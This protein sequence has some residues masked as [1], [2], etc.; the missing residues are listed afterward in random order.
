MAKLL[1]RRQGFTLVELLVVIAVIGILV[2][3]LLPAIQAA[4]EA[5][6]RT[7]CSNN[8]KQIGLACQNHHDVF[9]TFPSGGLAWSSPRTWLTPG[10]PAGADSQ[11]WGWAYQILPYME[12]RVVWEN[13]NDSEVPGTAI[14]S[15]SCP[16]LRMPTAFPYTQAGFNETRMMAD[17]VGNGGTWGGWGNFDNSGNSLDGPLSP[18]GRQVRL[19]QITDGVSNTLLIGEKYLNQLSPGPACND[20]QGWVDGW[21]NDTIAFVRGTAAS[22]PIETPIPDGRVS[23]C[24][25]VFGSPHSTLL[26][27]FCDG[28]VHS[29]SFSVDSNA[30]LWMCAGRDGAAFTMHD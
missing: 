23:G 1:G 3:L 11:A 6:R 14:S 28:S 21:D 2:A 12:Q 10:I 16:T 22:N 27:V 30:W 9:R 29:I 19:A 8:L 24:W 17:Y 20:D 18:S 13:P 15:Y 26:A 7:K 5:S 4:R 25:M